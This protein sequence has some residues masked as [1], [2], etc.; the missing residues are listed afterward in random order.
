MEIGHHNVEVAPITETEFSLYQ[1]L[2]S[3]ISGIIIK[4]TQKYLVEK[5]LADLVYETKTSGFMDLYNKV[6]GNRT[7]TTRVIDLM[8]TNETLWFRDASCWQTIEEAVIPRLVEKLEKGQPNVKIWSAASSSGQEAYSLAI[9]IDEYFKRHY[10]T[11]LLDRIRILGTDISTEIV[12]AA[13]HGVYDSFSM[14]RGLSESRIQQYFTKQGS[15]QWLLN[16]EIKN[17]VEFKLLNLKKPFTFF[18]KFDLVFCR[19]VTIY[20][21]EKM[22]EDLLE[23][24]SKTLNKDGVL[25]LGST[26]TLMGIRHTY[27]MQRHKTGVFYTHPE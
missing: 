15:N 20:F 3:D 22:K 2:L 4:P 11:N 1:N 26:E 12:E 18:E 9:L 16:P 7:L 27:K 6:R 5:R 17:R 14:S 8:T 19:N 10:K 13:M 23:R 21:S 25:F 24:I